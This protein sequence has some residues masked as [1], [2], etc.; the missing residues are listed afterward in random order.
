MTFIIIGVLIAVV[1]LALILNGV[2]D[3]SKS[4]KVGMSFKE[5]LDLTD[6]PIVTFYNNGKK[7]NFLLD[8]GSNYSQINAPLLPELKYEGI[9]NSLETFGMEGNK[10]TSEMC[11]MSVT[12]KDQEFTDIFCV[13]DLTN[14]FNI[15][16]QESGVQIHG[17][18][19]NNLFQKYKYILDFDKLI[20]Y[21]KCK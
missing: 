10:V 13:M 5:A 3:Y 19:G 9:K 1:F 21:S 16:K 17:I 4:K 12:Y 8:T 14:A 20:A 18:L 15:I 6:L 7:L 11:Q 2:E